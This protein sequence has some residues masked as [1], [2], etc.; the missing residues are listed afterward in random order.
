M[1]LISDQEHMLSVLELAR[2]GLG[3]TSPNPMVG[4]IIVQ[5]G[6]VVGEGWHRRCGSAHAEVN[7]IKAAG[8]KSFGATLFVNLEPC[9]HHGRT[10]PCVDQIIAAGIQEVVIAHAD[11]NPLTAGKSI[12]KLR[13]AGIRVRVGLCR[14][15]A[16]RLNE[17]FIKVHQQG[18]PFVVVKSAQTLDGKI[19]C[20]SGESKWITSSALRTY[21]RRR[22]DE[23]DAI[24]IGSKTAVKDNPRLNGHQKNKRLKKV[25]CDTQLKIS[26]DAALFKDTKA[27]D[28]II[29]TA[30]QASLSKVKA[31]QSRGVQVW[32]APLKGGHIDLKWAFK[33][34]AKNDILSILIEGGA[35][36]IG[37][38]LKNNLVD[39]VQCY[40]API[41]LGD[42]KALDAMTGMNIKTIKQALRLRDVCITDFQGEGLIEGYVLRNC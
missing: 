34:L 9:F 15:Q 11:V 1:S 37:A 6:Q 7:A 40:I 4:A 17:V 19:A 3:R 24:L 18:L 32:L 10:P 5:K 13:G 2:R 35:H 20:A 38:A 41:I 28:C 16:L 21:A 39:K 8:K 36:I 25:I 27:E 26:L 23:F 12:K 42:A 22:R 31:L 30:K 29:I 14:K 33:E